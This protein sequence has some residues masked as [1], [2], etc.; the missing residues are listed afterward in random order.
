[1]HP[2][3]G[4]SPRLTQRVLRAITVQLPSIP[5]MFFT[6]HT[7][8]IPIKISSMP[9]VQVIAQPQAIGT[10]YPLTHRIMWAIIPQLPSIPTMQSTYP[11]LMTPTNIP[12]MP[13][14][15]A[16]AQPPAIGTTS[17]LKLQVLGGISLQSLSIP[18]MQYTCPTSVG[19][20]PNSS[21]PRVLA[22][23]Q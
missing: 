20:I 6:F 9:P 3:L 22:A 1:M 8:M 2:V 4:S 21:M 13:P 15:Q 12:S 16:V 11:T 18:T 17:K 14:V 7:S 23:V 19:P 10:R 5:M